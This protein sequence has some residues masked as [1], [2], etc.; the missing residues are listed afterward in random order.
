MKYSAKKFEED[1]GISEKL[2]KKVLTILYA[3]NLKAEDF[4]S[5]LW[6]MRDWF[7]K[8][9]MPA[10]VEK[11]TD[12]EIQA[13]VDK[14]IIEKALWQSQ[15]PSD[16]CCAETAEELERAFNNMSMPESAWFFTALKDKTA[17][18]TYSKGDIVRV[19]IMRT[20]KWDHPSYG[21]VKITKKVIQ[22][23]VSNFSNRE[24][25]I[26]LAVDENHEPDHKA[27]AWFRDLVTENDGN[28]L[29]ADVELT[30]KGADILN[31]G[32]YKYFSPEIVFHKIDEESGKP[33][34]N[35]LIGGAF[36][37]R[38]F[39]K[40]MQPLMA[41]ES[42]ANGDNMGQSSAKEGHVVFFSHSKPMLK[43]LE[44]MAD[45]G[46][47]SSITSMQKSE[48]EK[49]YSELPAEDRS[50][51]INKKFAETLALF[52]EDAAPEAPVETPETPVET[53]ETPV[54]P[55]TPETPVEPPVVPEETEEEEEVE[56]EVPVAAS[57]T[58]QG[59]A[60]NEDGSIKITDAAAFSASVK[61]Q[62]K[63][64]AEYQREASLAACEK[65]L[66]PLVFSEKRKTRVVIPSQKK[67]IVAFAASLDEAKR[68]TF[69]SILGQLKS[70][71]AGTLGSTK[72]A[73]KTD[74]KKPETFSEDHAT[75]KYF[76]ETLKQDLKTAQ[77]SAA[78]FE[79]SKAQR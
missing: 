44:L 8:T 17:G 10:L 5:V 18:E 23:V 73:S 6:K 59:I 72:D 20:G 56:E 49:A 32:S 35:L 68:A 11:L 31:D 77:K 78:D 2:A 50:A 79:A 14:V 1:A 43:F 47:K 75:V 40:D 51:E 61:A 63:K 19:Q 65:S 67:M 15:C 28:D 55:E 33:Q 62:Q 12:E 70:V 25:K 22:D 4:S 71:P 42:A 53:P 27:L 26:D 76:M 7:I 45:L 52:D 69:F 54:V 30:K 16:I 9:K 37:N 48:L 60:F 46:E 24:R 58:L 36:T 41:S 57:E 39:F 29:Y 3:K 21:E 38:P 34:S 64:F 66:A 13:V 74:V